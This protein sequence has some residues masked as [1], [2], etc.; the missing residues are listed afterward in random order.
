MLGCE[1]MRT[2]LPSTGVTR[3]EWETNY[4]AKCTT[5][6]EPKEFQRAD[7]HA[8]WLYLAPWRQGFLSKLYLLIKIC[9]RLVHFGVVKQVNK[10]GRRREFRKE[11]CKSS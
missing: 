8:K 4:E 1:G 6:D 11:G 10:L 5:S 7:S 2:M 9:I 3:T